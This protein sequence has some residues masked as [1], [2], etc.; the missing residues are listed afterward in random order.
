MVNY[1]QSMHVRAKWS[2]RNEIESRL[3]KPWPLHK[4][5]VR[6]YHLEISWII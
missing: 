5:L 4:P 3:S 6:L 2:M 1:Y